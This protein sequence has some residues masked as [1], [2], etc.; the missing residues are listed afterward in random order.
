VPS[1][2]QPNDGDGPQSL[3]ADFEV[4][5]MDCEAKRGLKRQLGDQEET[6]DGED[7]GEERLVIR[8]EEDEDH[9]P[10]PKHKKQ[11]TDKER[12]AG[13]EVVHCGNETF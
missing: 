1:Q 5:G 7:D 6:D 3:P 8:E 11:K 13:A 4:D 10:Q 9:A 2:S 12:S